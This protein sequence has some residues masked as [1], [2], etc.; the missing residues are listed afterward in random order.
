MK[1]LF[2]VMPGLVIVLVFMGIFWSPL[3]EL[4]PPEFQLFMV[5]L[6]MPVMGVLA[7]HWLGKKLL[8]T[9]ND[10]N[11]DSQPFVKFA[12]I[13]FYVAIPISIALGG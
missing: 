12:R 3:Y 13:A 2:R 5:K 4:L 1:N 6:F 10:W 8:P 9:V 11:D 7:A